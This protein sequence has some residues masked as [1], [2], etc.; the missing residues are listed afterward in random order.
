MR[1]HNK[2]WLLSRMKTSGSKRE[3]VQNGSFADERH[4]KVR[5]LLEELPYYESI[6]STPKVYNGKIKFD[7][8][9]RFLRGKIGCDWDEVYSEII[10]RIPTA[11]LEYKEF[12]FWFVA[13]KVE[14]VNEQLWNTKTQKFIW[15][16]EP[17]VLR[18]ISEIKLN[19][20]F[21]EFYVHLITHQL[22]HIPQRSFKKIAV[23]S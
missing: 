3:Y 1:E 14:I 4:K 2:R 22:M 18:H 23:K 6:K 20:E 15:T 21:K 11:L 8:L 19:P 12:I 7:L 16:G 13:D 17:Y 5:L 9:V 10:S